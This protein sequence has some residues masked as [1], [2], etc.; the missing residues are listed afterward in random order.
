MLKKQDGEKEVIPNVWL[1]IKIQ[2][3]FNRRKFKGVMLF[4]F[5]RLLPYCGALSISVYAGIHV[6]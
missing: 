4:F 3:I 1:H 2:S 5:Y 6:S